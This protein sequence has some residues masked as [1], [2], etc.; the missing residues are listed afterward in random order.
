MT[1]NYKD[2]YNK[3]KYGKCCEKGEKGDPGEPGIPGPPGPTGPTGATG[4]AGP[5]G[6][7]GPAGPAGSGDGSTIITNILSD[8]S[9]SSIDVSGENLSINGNVIFNN[10]VIIGDLSTNT[11][12]ISGET[13]ENIIERQTKYDISLSSIDVSGENLSINGNAIFNNHVIIGDLSTNT[14]TISGETVENI[15]ERQTKYDISLSSVDVSGENL[16]VNGNTIFNNHLTVMDLST[17]TLTISGET[18]ENIIERQTKYDISLSSV[19]VSGEN[20]TV[21]GNA[22]F[23]NHVTIPDLSTNTLTISGETVQNIVD[24]EANRIVDSKIIDNIPSTIKIKK[25]EIS[26]NLLEIGENG[27]TVDILSSKIKTD[28]ICSNRIDASSIFINN[29]PVNLNSDGITVNIPDNISFNDITTNTLTISDET[30]ED[31]IIRETKYDISLSSVDVSG[32]NLTVNGKTNFNGNAIFNNHLTVTDLSTNTLTISGETVEDIIERETKYDISLSSVDVSGENLTVNGNAIFNN[33]LSVPDLST[34]TLTI[35]GETVENII[36]RQTKYDISLSS[37]DVSGEN[38]TVNGN[39]IFN[40]HVIIGDLSTNTLT[41]SGETV[42]DIIERETKYDI[43][44]S[45]I[46][47]SGDK[48]IIN[49][50]LSIKGGVE[51]NELSRNIIKTTIVETKEIAVDN[52]IPNNTDTININTREG[53]DTVTIDASK[54]SLII[55][56][57]SSNKMVCNDISVNHL[58]LEDYNITKYDFPI[59]T[60]IFKDIDISQNNTQISFFNSN[61]FPESLKVKL[62]DL[63]YN[64]LKDLSNNYYITAQQIKFKDRFIY[65][66]YPVLEYDSANRYSENNNITIFKYGEQNPQGLEDNEKHRQ[67]DIV[68]KIFKNPEIW[69]PEGYTRVD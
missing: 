4:P 61:N 60:R 13:V 19:D 39:A 54:A 28:K 22:I 30:V 51:T 18:V 52:I 25:I 26:G 58:Q 68:V 5:A 32:E 46:D 23:N 35:S 40:N 50:S 37:V 66:F 7:T 11:L 55:R 20:L 3:Q 33:H 6:P 62:D 59:F 38:L 2:Y 49:G 67:L 34:N 44:L 45:N 9:L 27:T 17:N 42:E 48:L 21:N 10:D 8:I 41:I 31:I 57:I 64:K 53:I 12:T 63:S 14:L 56:D 47:V 43:S 36:E 65:D 1:S 29:Q 24:R 69:E 15:I 16:T